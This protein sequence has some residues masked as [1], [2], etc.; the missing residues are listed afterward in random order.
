MLLYS[1]ASMFL[2]RRAVWFSSFFVGAIFFVHILP[3]QEALT[4]DSSRK[5]NTPGTIH[6]ISPE[7][8]KQ[9]QESARNSIRPEITR[10]VDGWKI[11]TPHFTVFTAENTQNAQIAASNLEA[12]WAEAATVAAMWRDPAA[13]K[14]NRAKNEKAANPAFRQ[15]NPKI[16][17]HFATL[18]LPDEKIARN[19]CLFSED[20]GA[21]RLDITPS[22]IRNPE[23][24]TQAVRHAVFQAVL[25]VGGERDYFPLWIQTGMAAVFSGQP[26]PASV[27]KWQALPAPG[28]ATTLVD[29]LRETRLEAETF[30]Q[31]AHLWARYYLTAND[32]AHAAEFLNLLNAIHE[33]HAPI[34]ERIRQQDL[35]GAIHSPAA[36]RH[37]AQAEIAGR[38]RNFMNQISAQQNSGTLLPAQWLREPGVGVPEVIWPDRVNILTTDPDAEPE[39]APLPEAF[40]PIYPEMALI[41]KLAGQVRGEISRLE[42][43]TAAEIAP[44]VAETLAAEPEAEFSPTVF[45]YDPS[46]TPTGMRVYEHQ[47]ET[48]RETSGETPGKIPEKDAKRLARV[49]EAITAG[50]AAISATL[51]TDGTILFPLRDG[52]RL[53][54]LFH[55]RDRAYL[56]QYYEGDL[57]LSVTLKNGDVF[58]AVLREPVEKAG[59]QT[60][61]ILGYQ[62]AAQDGGEE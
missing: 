23:V 29:A 45:R 46:D 48:P 17:V 44:Q 41:L 20:G 43:N 42:K 26:L 11:E 50:P 40:K 19:S 7:T 38:V 37:Q 18:P 49:Y 22:L 58:H 27:D 33:T 4:R 34:F 54:E 56:V 35:A 57:V 10:T 61:E 15:E 52:Q 21:F 62:P 25:A 36:A 9:A 30:Q 12:L 32:A 5:F 6:L 55:P 60:V 1:S 13:A 8:A 51:D 3:A 47:I 39:M 59:R 53:R 28:S 24:H 2:A 31:A 16:P 14:L